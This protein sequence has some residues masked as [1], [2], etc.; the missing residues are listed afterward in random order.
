MTPVR[1]SILVQTLREAQHNVRM[2]RISA[3]IAQG[4]NTPTGRVSDNGGGIVGSRRVMHVSRGPPLVHGGRAAR[5]ERP[6]LLCRT[7]VGHSHPARATIKAIIRSIRVIDG[8]EV[9][10]DMCKTG[11]PPTRTR[12]ASLMD[13]GNGGRMAG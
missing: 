11:G 3:N 10:P 6:R 1:T 4:P 2:H 8:T 5:V 13:G 9:R 7:T 12:H